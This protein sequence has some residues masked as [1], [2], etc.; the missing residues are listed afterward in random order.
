LIDPSAAE[1]RHVSTDLDDWAVVANASYV[2]PLDNL[3]RISPGFSDALCRASTGDGIVRR[4]LYTDSDVKVLAYRRVV[5]LNTIDLASLRGDLAERIL[6]IELQPISKEARR[7]EK[8]INEQLE[9]DRGKILGGLLDLLVKVLAA[10]PEVSTTELPRM[11]DF[12]RVLLA[13][14]QVQGWDTFGTYM[15]SQSK[16]AEQAVESSHLAEVLWRFMNMKVNGQRRPLWSGTASELLNALNELVTRPP[17]GWPSTPALLSS[18]LKRLAPDVRRTYGLS[19]VTNRTAKQRT[20]HI[21]RVTVSDEDDS[22]GP[23]V[24]RSA[25]QAVSDADEAKE[26]EELSMSLDEHAAGREEV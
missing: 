19:L 17:R 18:E 9:A 6:L 23:P 22:D 10:L 14:D 8:E 4:Q 13:V 5:V 24:G 15:D 16:T 25:E 11:A 3:S 7:E 1:L 12:A 2:V 20:W 21:G 26:G